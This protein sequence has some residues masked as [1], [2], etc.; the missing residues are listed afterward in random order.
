MEK[1]KK[2]EKMRFEYDTI[3][4]KGLRALISMAEDKGFRL[5]C[6]LTS[7]QNTI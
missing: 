4:C 6:S 7:L 3:Q 1:K 5:L 2:Q